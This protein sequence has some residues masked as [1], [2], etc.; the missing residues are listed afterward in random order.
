MKTSLFALVGLLVLVA[1]GCGKKDEGPGGPPPCPPAHT[2][3]PFWGRCVTQA[4]C[5]PGLVQH[6]EQ[7]SMCANPQTGQLTGT[8]T[9]GAGF[10]LTTAGCVTQGMCQAGQGQTG[11][12]CLPAVSGGSQ[13]NWGGYQQQPQYQQPY[14]QPQYQ[15]PYFNPYVRYW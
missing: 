2:A 9:C 14:Y 10:V 8:M 4:F 13:Y 1:I 15:Q 5:G 6:P 7:P 3:S 12:Q 11:T